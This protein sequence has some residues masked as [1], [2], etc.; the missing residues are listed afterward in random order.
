MVGERAAEQ[1]NDETFL[2]Q[3]NLA[4]R[5]EKAALLQE[6]QICEELYKKSKLFTLNRFI[7]S[8]NDLK[9]IVIV[10]VILIPLCIIFI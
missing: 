7:P 6:F 2:R 1:E 3:E 4:L 8:K 10:D 9:K 5:Q